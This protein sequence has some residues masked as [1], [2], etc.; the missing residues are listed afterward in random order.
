MKRIV[1]SQDAVAALIPQ[2]TESWMTVESLTDAFTNGDALYVGTIDVIIAF[3][4]I[5][6][7]TDN[8]GFEQVKYLWVHPD[9]RGQSLAETLLRQILFNKRRSNILVLVPPSNQ[10]CK[11]VPKFGFEEVVD[12]VEQRNWSKMFPGESSKNKLFWKTPGTKS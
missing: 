2:V 3:V 10:L 11:L 5:T 4:L 1:P 8:N 12:W 7:V 9:S 6:P